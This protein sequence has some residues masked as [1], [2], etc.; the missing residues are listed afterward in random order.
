TLPGRTLEPILR[1]APLP[2]WILMHFQGGGE[3]WTSPQLF[4]AAPAPKQ[5]PDTEPGPAVT[6]R[7]QQVLADLKRRWDAPTLLTLA[8]QR[9]GE[10]LVDNTPQLTANAANQLPQQAQ[11]NDYGKRWAYN[12]RIKNEALTQM[13]EPNPVRLGRQMVPLWLTGKDRSD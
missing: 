8:R 12:S 4:K 3:G 13:E 9:G 6:Q 2:D 10:P 7:R 11:A 1:R 5:A